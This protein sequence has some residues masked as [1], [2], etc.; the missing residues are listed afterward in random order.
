[1]SQTHHWTIVVNILSSRYVLQGG[2]IFGV[3]FLTWPPAL[4]KKVQG[5]IIAE[6]MSCRRSEKG[7][8]SKSQLSSGFQALPPI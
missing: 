2:T 7:E 3:Y 4:Y 8:G 6:T 5:D 1:M